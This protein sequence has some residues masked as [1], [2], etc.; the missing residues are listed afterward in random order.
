MKKPA[1]RSG[2][3]K[4]SFASLPTPHKNS[5]KIAWGYH[6][7]SQLVPASLRPN[8]ERDFQRAWK[9]SEEWA[10]LDYGDD[11][12]RNEHYLVALKP[13]GKI[14]YRVRLR[15]GKTIRR[16]IDLWPWK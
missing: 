4:P 3:A 14:V 1:R 6:G 15:N 12:R 10:V 9:H 13:S 8:I 2:S 16:A 11:A 7:G 5:P